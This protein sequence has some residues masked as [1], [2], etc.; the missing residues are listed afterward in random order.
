MKFRKAL[1]YIL[2]LMLL[3]ADLGAIAEGLT[4]KLPAALKTVGEEAFY[5]NTS[6]GKVVVPDG[7]DRIEARAFANSSV[8]EVELPDTLTYIADDAFAGCGDIAFSVPENCYAYEWCVRM[9]YIATEASFEQ[10]EVWLRVGESA[11][12]PASF[13][14]NAGEFTYESSDPD[15]VTVDQTGTIRAIDCLPGGYA[16]ITATSVKYPNK[17]AQCRVYTSNEPIAIEFTRDCLYVGGKLATENVTG[18]LPLTFKAYN[19]IRLTPENADPGKLTFETGDS[20]VATVDANGVVTAKAISGETTVTVKTENGLSAMVPLKVLQLQYWPDLEPA[21]GTYSYSMEGAF[22]V[23]FLDGY[24][25]C[26]YLEYDEN[27]FDAEIDLETDTVRFRVIGDVE[28]T[29]TANIVLRRTINDAH[30]AT[31]TATLKPASKLGQVDFE[32]PEVYMTA[33]TTR[34]NAAVC[35][36][37]TMCTFS[38]ESDHPDYV[39]VDAE[40][41]LTAHKDTDEKVE[42]VTITAR[43]MQNAGVT[44]TCKVYVDASADQL[45]FK[46]DFVK[47]GGVYGSKTDQ[48]YLPYAAYDLVHFPEGVTKD[49][50]IYEFADTSVATANSYGTIFA[51]VTSGETTLTIRTASGLSA[52]VPLKILKLM[53]W[54]EVE[55]ASGTCAMG[56]EGSFNINYDEGYYQSYA[57]IYDENLLDVEMD[58]KSDLRVDTIKYRVIGNITE[59]TTTTIS[60]KASFESMQKWSYTLTLLPAP[61]QGQVSFAHSAL[62]MQAGDMLANAAICAENTLCEF[63]YESDHPEYVSVGADGTLTAHKNTG[64]GVDYV[65]ITARSKQ[66][67]SVT[68]TCRV[69]V[70]DTQEPISFNVDVVKMGGVSGGTADKLNPQLDAYRL[71]HYPESEETGAITFEVADS[72]IAVVNADGTITAKAAS[73]ETTLTMHTES[74]LTAS[75]PLKVFNLQTTPVIEPAANAIGVKTE[76][77]FRIQYNEGSYACSYL[78]YDADLLDARLDVISELHADTVSYRVTGDIT[79][80]VST[81]IKVRASSTGAVMGT[82]TLTIYPMPSWGQVTIDSDKYM[83][84]GMGDTSLSV[85]AACAEGTLDEIRYSSSREQYVT[86]DPI[87]GALTAVKPMPKGMTATITAYALHNVSARDTCTVATFDAPTDI[88]FARSYL[89]LG[90]GETLNLRED[91]LLVYTPDTARCTFKYESSAPE[92][93]SVDAKGTITANAKGSAIITA[94][95][96]NGITKSITVYAYESS[97]LPTL[98]PASD[99]K[100]TAMQGTFRVVFPMSSYQ[101][102]RVEYDQKL[103]TDLAIDRVTEKQAD[104]ITYTVAEITEAAD[105][106]IVLKKADGTVLATYA[107]RVVPA[108]KAGDVSLPE[109]QRDLVLGLGN[110]TYRMTPVCAEGTLSDFKFT[111]DR[112]EYVSV[113]ADT[114]VLNAKKITPDGVYAAITAVSVTNPEASV[115]GR[116]TVVAAP[117]S[118]TRTAAYIKTGAGDSVDLFGEGLFVMQPAGA[119]GN[120]VFASSNPEAAKVDENGKVTCLKK[121][122]AVISAHTYNGLIASITVYVYDYQAAPQLSADAISIGEESTGKLDIG[123]E[124]GSYRR[125]RVESASDLI[126]IDQIDVT[127]RTFTDTVTFK[128]GSVSKMTEAK[129]RILDMEGA[130]LAV[131]TVKIYPAPETIT[132]TP[133]QITMGMGE[134]GYAVQAVCPD[135][136]MCNFIYTSEDENIVAVVPNGALTAKGVGTAKIIVSADNSSAKAECTVIVKPKPTGISMTRS[137]LKLGEG[138]TFNIAE[139]EDLLKIEPAD[140]KTQLHYTSS[141]VYYATVDQNGLVTAK[142]PGKATIRVTTH[143]GFSCAIT[144]HVFEKGTVLADIQP[145]QIEV[146]ANMNGSIRVTFNEGCYSRFTAEPESSL[147]TVTGY[148]RATDDGGDT[149]YFH[150]GMATE[151]TQTRVKFVNIDGTVIGYANV[152]ILPGPTTVTIADVDM[153]IGERDKYVTVTYGEADRMCAFEYESDA[154]DIAIVDNETNLITGLSEGTAHITARSTN[155]AAV[156]QFTVTVHRD[157]VLVDYEDLEN[158]GI[159]VGDTIDIPAPHV[160]DGNNEE[161][162][163]AIT[164]AVDNSAIAKVEGNRVT[165]VK[166]GSTMLTASTSNGLSAQFTLTVSQDTVTGVAFDETDVTLYTDDHGYEDTVAL[167][168]HVLGEDITHGSLRY[169]LVGTSSA[170]TVTEAGIVHAQSVGDAQVTAAAFNGVTAAVPCDV[171]VRKLTSTLALDQTA[172]ELGEGMTLTLTPIFDAGTGARV[173]WRTSDPDVALVSMDGEVIAIGAGTARISAQVQKDGKVYNNLEAY[174]DI[175]VIAGPTGISMRAAELNLAKGEAVNI[176]DLYTIQSKTES[177][178]KQVTVKAQDETIAQIAEDKL[179][180]LETGATVLLFT[181]CNGYS[182]QMTLNVVESAELAQNGFAW[183]ATD[184]SMISGLKQKPEIMLNAEG[185]RRGYTLEIENPEGKTVLLLDE[186]GEL[187]AVETGT[188]ALRMMLNADETQPK[189]LAASVNITVYTYQDVQMDIP[190]EKYVVVGEIADFDFAITYPENLICDIPLTYT[191]SN[192]YVQFAPMHTVLSRDNAYAGTGIITAGDTKGTSTD[193]T[194]FENPNLTCVIRIPMPRYRAL[195]ISEYDKNAGGNSLPFAQNNVSS[196]QRALALSSVDGERYETKMLKNPSKGELATAIGSYFKDANPEDVSVIYVVSHGHSE[197]TTSNPKL[198]NFGVTDGSRIY[199]KSDPSSYVTSED[200]M[201]Y[202][203]NIRGNVVLLLDACNSG[204]F[205]IDT[206]EQMAVWGNISVMTAQRADVRASWFNGDSNATTIEFFTYALCYGLGFEMLET[207]LSSMPADNNPTDN[208]LTIDELFHYAYSKTI[209]TI[210]EKRSAYPSKVVVGGGSAPESGWYQ[211]PQIYIGLGL[212]DTILSARN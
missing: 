184:L 99:V 10:D 133:A 32:N 26:Y 122:S 143:N 202:M 118:L 12:N 61:K 96:Y 112:P 23:K 36:A 204:Q 174:A 160:F 128:T 105:T 208:A 170:I 69:Y 124:S 76:G 56:M 104:T 4:L 8:S 210:A 34:A 47:M 52:S 27:L 148:D 175:T 190:A 121:G 181:T 78:E 141:N 138:E 109:Q 189:T 107:L 29:T 57:L 86:V 158:V 110:D 142:H 17:T 126:T 43:S 54:P 59:P 84:I 205:I 155:S 51:H 75:V 25:D 77:T 159:A 207:T 72:N 194:F 19:L 187:N 201:N 24:Y 28:K 119:T 21:S 197:A 40:G 38:Y 35:L 152:T 22:H 199:S 172:A 106:Q 79:E 161:M 156:A 15:C 80:P 162:Q 163:V 114:G 66:N 173:V 146:G 64:D 203:R 82:F 136:T 95:S 111:S 134:E 193:L 92:R 101:S 74:G 206:S 127:T 176:S 65:T 166:A 18:N 200:L 120:L 209:D 132:C 139:E 125:Y 154:P 49:D 89:K 46:T 42:Y 1:A 113:D 137:I 98:E 177:V 67:S 149:V 16:V 144:V 129:I 94:T 117:E 196:L 41:V 68:A 191:L 103:L 58:M 85:H 130:E 108:P 87:T 37:D 123:F 20:A 116:V 73:G 198:F 39:S 30:K 62:R 147:I 140:C 11:V 93:I 164:Y 55:P 100:G 188:A 81:E 165:G 192:D 2:V 186:A 83:E 33:G 157:P 183:T 90:V 171:H 135:G 145:E 169:S 102:Y 212:G 195:I 168:A 7:T 97:D 131:C 88:A 151:R 48:L 13:K 60:A 53:Y 63:T 31:F 185:V 179:T 167:S 211:Q 5:G 44:A 178:W 182:G 150:A 71:I 91:D 153:S 70:R 180:A 45:Y 115:T 9:G 50:L 14:G 6:L 3:F